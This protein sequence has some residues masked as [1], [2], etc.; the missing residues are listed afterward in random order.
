MNDEII[1][2]LLYELE[3]GTAY[4]FSD[5]SIVPRICAGVYTIWNERTLIYVGMSGRSLSAETITEHRK[6]NSRARGLVTRLKAHASG[7]RSGDQFCVYIS[8]RLVLPSLTSEQIAQIAEGNLSFDRL[9]R[10]YIHEQLSFRFVET[11]SDGT[12]CQLE[13]A[14]KGG[15]L[16]AGKRFLNPIL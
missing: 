3:N 7:R 10:D 4:S 1:K 9:I 16:N 8:D 13:N 2:N 6:S 12:A 5:W 11:E 15:A 14:I